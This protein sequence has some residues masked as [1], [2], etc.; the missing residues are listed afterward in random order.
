MSYGDVAEYLEEGS[1][2]SV[3]AVMSTWGADA[4]WWRVVFADGAPPSRRP[5]RA[6]ERYAQ[7]GTPLTP[8]GARVDMARA[9]WDGTP[10][11][12]RRPG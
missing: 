6:L 11:V 7:E 1:A 3:G 5:E 12:A 8:D 2:R 9:R 10:R 4:P